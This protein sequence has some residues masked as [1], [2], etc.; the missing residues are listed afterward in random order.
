MN[1]YIDELAAMVPMCSVVSRFVFVC[2][3]FKFQVKLGKLVELGTSSCLLSTIFD[4]I[5]GYYY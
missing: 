2:F 5:N 3:V 1:M 4:D